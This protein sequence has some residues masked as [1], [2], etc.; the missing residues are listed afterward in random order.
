MLVTLRSVFTQ[1]PPV[2]RAWTRE[3]L[4]SLGWPS[5]LV[6]QA[7]NEVVGASSPASSPTPG[8]SRTWLWVSLGLAALAGG[9]VAVWAL[10][11]RRA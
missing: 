6:K 1:Q 11:R 7:Y 4:Y 9:G 8:T 3:A 2:D 10:R 5:A